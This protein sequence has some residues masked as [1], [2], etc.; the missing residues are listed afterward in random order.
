MTPDAL[1]RSYLY[2]PANA[3]DKLAKSLQRGAD[4]LILDLEDA[5]LARDKTTARHAIVAWLRVQDEDLATQL[6]VRINSGSERVND[7]KALAGIP[8]VTGIVTAKVNDPREV[9]SIADALTSLGDHST[10]LMP[11]IETAKAVLNC[12]DIAAQPR[13]HQLQIGEVDLSAELGMDAAGDEH[14]FAA[15]RTMI[16]L[17]SAA[18]EISPPV[19]PVSRITNDALALKRSTERVRRLG[20]VGRACIH[21]AQLSAVHG[22]FTPT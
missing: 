3:P 19:G 10:L 2:V 14:E 8:S 20:F 13:V 5:V 15:I 7:L 17:A 16:V 11:M 9:N 22:I 6:W 21:P 4:A 18:A 1:P 12:A